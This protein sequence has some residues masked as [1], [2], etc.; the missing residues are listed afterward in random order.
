MSNDEKLTKK[1]NDEITEEIKEGIEE[2]IRVGVDKMIDPKDVV[3]MI[4]AVIKNEK[5]IIIQTK[6]KLP[7]D[8]E[9]V[10]VNYSPKHNAVNFVFKD[11]SVGVYPELLFDA[12]DKI[13]A[14]IA[15]KKLQG[16]N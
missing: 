4:A 1:V 9:C 8:L 15:E 3:T 5:P 7:R 11:F 14:V 10:V 13:K 2:E 6:V 16:L 12:I